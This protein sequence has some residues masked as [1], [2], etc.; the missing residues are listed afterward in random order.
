MKEPKKEETKDDHTVI[1]RPKYKELYEAEAAN[2]RLW[3]QKV[4]DIA[5]ESGVMAKHLHKVEKELEEKKEYIDL[6]KN[7]LKEMNVSEK[8]N[9]MKLN[10][11]EGELKMMKRWLDNLTEG[12]QV[13]KQGGKEINIRYSIL[14]LWQ[15]QSVFSNRNL[16]LS[17]PTLPRL[18]HNQGEGSSIPSSAPFFFGLFILSKEHLLTSDKIRD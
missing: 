5:E 2:A 18:S 13:F 8:I 3:K 7:S 11:L 6:I 17:L 4:R 1:E 9:I 16:I 12:D 15:V 14:S 10:F